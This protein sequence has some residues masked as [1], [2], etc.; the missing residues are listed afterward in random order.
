[1]AV[2]NVFSAGAIVLDSTSQAAPV[3]F[4]GLSSQ[5]I[6]INTAIRTQRA[7]GEV[8]ESQT[9]IVGRA[10]GIAFST[11]QVGT[12]LGELGDRGICIKSD[13]THVGAEAY[14]LLDE[15]KAAGVP[16][17]VHAARARIANKTFEIAKILNDADIPFAVQTGHEGYV[18]KTRVLI[19]EVAH[20]AAHGLDAQDA[21]AAVTIDSAKLLGLDDRIGS[22]EVGKDGDVTM[23][24]GD[25]FEY[26]TQVCGVLIE[27][28]MVS[29]TCR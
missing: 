9:T 18:P 20:Y 14:L 12:V 25:P 15:I 8:Y 7:F 24:T 1:M 10:P 27:G 11:S 13:G 26:L 5:S 17:F 23:F 3:G 29:E 28:E 16:V 22:L 21:L 19:F 2:P 4:A 6:D